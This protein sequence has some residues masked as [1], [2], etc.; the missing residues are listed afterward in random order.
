MGFLDHSTN[1]IIVDA[2]LT[3]RGRELLAAQNGNDKTGFKIEKF[4]L[5]DDEVDYTIIQKYGRTVG[6]EKIIKNTPVF[7]AQTK[8]YLAQKYRMVTLNDP[9]VTH[10]PS[11]SVSPS[12]TLSF[13]STTTQVTL[14]VKTVMSEG[15]TVPVEIIDN[16]FYV[17]L[18]SK[19]LAISTRQGAR[20]T[21]LDIDESTSLLTGT[22]V[23]T[24][25]SNNKG[26]GTT[27]AE[28]V[29]T[30]LSSIDDTLFTVYGSGGTTIK[31]II[32][33]IGADS[34][35]RTDIPI[36]ITR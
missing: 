8:A 10:L 33:I 26:Q 16:E 36:S 34:G 27:L 25:S 21:A 17:I 28:I 18:P 22:Y 3:D 7:E 5:S 29:L 31:T 12:G 32:S 24:T 14:F 6:K 13:N 11:L 19:L 35:A 23:V 9:L 30:K 4:S 15:R 20:Q 1:N 2:V